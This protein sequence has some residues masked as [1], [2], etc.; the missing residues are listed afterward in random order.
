M[1]TLPGRPVRPSMAVMAGLSLLF[2]L[3]ACETKVKEADQDEERAESPAAEMREKQ[4]APAFPKPIDWTRVGEA[5]GKAGA[6]Q[7]GEVYKVGMP[8]GDLHVIL[9]GVQVKPALAL[10]SWVGFKQTGQ[11][12]VTAMGDLVLLE[13]EVGPVTARLQAGGVEQT[14]IH[15]H[16]LHESPHV[17]YVHIRG[18]GDA[19]KIATA[20]HAAL[21]LTKTPL[22]AAAGKPESLDLDT[23]QVH[24]ILGQRGTVNGGVYQV[25]VPRA[26]AVTED[27]MD[28]PPAMGVATALNFQPTPGKKA[29][30]TGDFVLISSEVNLVIRTLQQNGIEITA[31]HSHMLDESPRLFFMHFWANDDVSA[32]A[33]GLRAA[34]DKMNVKS[35]SH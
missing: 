7:P 10:G 22:G 19:I 29:A 15:N 25:S 31:L 11:N 27:E 33:A 26:E 17:M 32:L 30:I 2:V 6:L 4:S 13:N 21:A 1:K 34:L 18:H 5:L 9:G 35:A 28:V 12:E 3:T 23:A 20:L 16:L 24:Q 14:A 8:R